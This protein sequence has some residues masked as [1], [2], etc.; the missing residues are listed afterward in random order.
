MHIGNGNTRTVLPRKDLTNRAFS[1]QIT[2]FRTVHPNS[3]T[4]SARRIRS[5]FSS[6][7]NMFPNGITP[8]LR[9]F[10]NAFLEIFSLLG[11]WSRHY[12]KRERSWKGGVAV[13]FFST[14]RYILLTVLYFYVDN[15]FL[16]K[17]LFFLS[18]IYL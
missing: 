16:F 2:G 12:F 15:N 11:N 7:R 8:I 13:F 3:K 1:M 5:H 14:A 18:S 9:K 4:R 6:N 10:K 17:W